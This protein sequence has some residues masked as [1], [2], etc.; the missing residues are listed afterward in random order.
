MAPCPAAREHVCDEACGMCAGAR[1]ERSGSRRREAQRGSQPLS[2]QL[3]SSVRPA[4]VTLR[5]IHSGTLSRQRQGPDRGP[6]FQG[7][8]VRGLAGTLFA[9]SPSAPA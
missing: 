5:P 2:V 7:Y 8:P 3:S 6:C 1:A 9:T 4:G